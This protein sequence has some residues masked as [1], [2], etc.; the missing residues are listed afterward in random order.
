MK[1]NSISIAVFL[2]IHN[3]LLSQVNLVPNP[4]FEY[5]NSCDSFPNGVLVGDVPPWDS[6]TD[7]SPDIFNACNTNLNNFSSPSNQ[8]GYQYPHSGATYIGEVFFGLGQPGR[9]YAQVKL[10]SILVD[11]KKYCVSFYVSKSNSYNYAINNIGMYLSQTHTYTPS[12]NRLNFI[13]QINDTNIVSDVLNWTL[14]SGQYTA[15]GGEQY[16]IIG[17]FYPNSATDTLAINSSGLEDWSYYYI[18]DVSIIDVSTHAY[19]GRDTTIH[20]GDSVY[21]GRPPQVG[22]NEDCIWYVNNVPIDTIAGMW[23]HPTDTVNYVLKQ[24]ICGYVTYDTVHINVYG[25]GVDELSMGNMQLII[26]PNPTTGIFTVSTEGAKIKEIKVIDV[27]GEIIC[28]STSQNSTTSLDLSD[29]A[30]GI[31][32]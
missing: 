18:D 27:V 31:Y 1:K 26:S 30:K 7:G 24:T 21:V 28:K 16:I 10:D 9:E 3:L 14:I 29:K 5:I 15:T 17:N 2:F 19:A 12:T 22:L 8:W 4:S 25:M 32:L 6:P 23:V 11:Q 13:P 20:I